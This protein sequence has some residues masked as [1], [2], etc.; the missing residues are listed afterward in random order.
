MSSRTEA[1]EAVAQRGG[2]KDL[3]IEQPLTWIISRHAMHSL[4]TV[5]RAESESVW[6]RFHAE[7]QHV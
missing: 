7:I 2:C 1:L 4:R 3:P 6:L 5:S